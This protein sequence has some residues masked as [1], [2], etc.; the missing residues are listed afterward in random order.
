V[1]EC[2]EWDV[3]C[4][5]YTSASRDADVRLQV[6]SWCFVD[7]TLPSIV[8][9]TAVE[10]ATPSDRFKVE[11]L[12][13]RSICGRRRGNWDEATNH[14]GFPHAADA[15]TGDPP[16]TATSSEPINLYRKTGK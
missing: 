10:D 1:F 5:F 4:S 2:S 7:V 11:S 14:D 15:D 3:I 13:L 8:L 12:D 16:S 6:P 9:L